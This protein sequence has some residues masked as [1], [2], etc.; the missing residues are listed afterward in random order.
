MAEIKDII[1]RPIQN[2]DERLVVFSIRRKVFIVEQNVPE[3]IEYDEFEDE[4]MHFIGLVN[5]LPVGA[6]RLSILK[7][8]QKVERIAT[9]K[10]YRGLGMGRMMVGPSGT[11]P[12]ASSRLG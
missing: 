7:D 11:E 8:M 6:G 2:E 5:G 4:A 10:E 3:D 1:C 9:L 12:T